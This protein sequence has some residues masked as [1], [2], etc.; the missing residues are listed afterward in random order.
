MNK[1]ILIRTPNPRLVKIMGSALKDKVE[2]T[3]KI[4]E[5]SSMNKSNINTQRSMVT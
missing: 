1:E 4:Q 5:E 3:V 2:S